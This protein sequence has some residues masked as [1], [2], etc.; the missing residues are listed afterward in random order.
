[1]FTCGMSISG[2]VSSP[3]LPAQPREQIQQKDGSAAADHVE[4]D[5]AEDDVRFEFERKEPEQER[6][7]NAHDERA[8]HANRPALRP[9]ADEGAKQSP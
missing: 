1:M 5:A 9:I 6:K 8:Q 7:R 4:R 2:V 3:V